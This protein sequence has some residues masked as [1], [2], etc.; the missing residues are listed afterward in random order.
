MELPT[1]C[2]VFPYI[3]I[4][5]FIIIHIAIFLLIL[6][7]IQNVEKLAFLWGMINWAIAIGALYF[8]VDYFLQFESE[9]LVMTFIAAIIS[10]ITEDIGRFIVFTFIYKSKNHNFN[11]SLIF[12]AGHGGWESIFIMMISYIPLLLNF[13]AIKN[14]KDEKELTEKELIKTYDHYKNGIS[15]QDIFDVISR[16][17]GNLFHMGAFVIIYRFSLNRKD[18]KYIIFFIVLLI[19]HYCIDFTS[20]LIFLYELNMW[21]NLIY[22]GLAILITVIGFFVWKE[23]N[24]K[25]YSDYIFEGKNG[26][27]EEMFKMDDINYDKIS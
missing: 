20:Q 19:A 23:N 22:M 10:L 24:N 6:K 14:A 9:S 27:I 11:N 18:K 1:I 16:F 21:F 5:I 8:G 4:G 12:G 17:L 25:E 15:G 7:F 26:K 3:F 2:F 13:Y